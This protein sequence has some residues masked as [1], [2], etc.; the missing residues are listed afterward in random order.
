MSKEQQKFDPIEALTE[1]FD[2]DQRVMLASIVGSLMLSESE[3]RPPLSGGMLR[4]DLH[5]EATAN[6]GEVNPGNDF[7]TMDFNFV[8]DSLVTAKA[9]TLYPEGIVRLG[10]HP[11]ANP[12]PLGLRRRRLS[13]IEILQTEAYWGITPGCL[14]RPSPR[15]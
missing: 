12:N 10:S 3:A 2:G 4:T 8:L 6:Y 9:V 14:D 1:Q 13:D 11:G 5:D 7:T 15:W